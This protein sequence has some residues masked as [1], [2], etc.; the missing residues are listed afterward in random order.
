[1][2]KQIGDIENTIQQHPGGIISTPLDFTDPAK[3][4]QIVGAFLTA[5]PDVKGVFAV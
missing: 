1:M 4:S 2:D 5:N 3:M